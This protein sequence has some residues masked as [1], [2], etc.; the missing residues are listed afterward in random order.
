MTP[1]AFYAPL[2]PPA[3]PNPSGDREIARNLLRA[4]T[5]AQFAPDLASELR[6]F[7]KHGDAAAQ[8]G[9]IAE[10]AAQIPD[11]IARGRQ[12]GWRLW[13]TYHNYYKAPDLLGPAVAQALNIP[14]VQIEST[15][16]RKRLAGPWARF[17]EIA[18]AAADAAHVIFYFTRRDAVAL[19]D[20]APDGQNLAHLKPFLAAE[21][22]PEA[23]TRDGPVLVAAMMRPGDKLESYRLIAQSMARMAEP[24]TLAIAGDGSARAEVEALM[25]PLGDRVQFLGLLDAPNLSAAYHGARL[26]FW[27]GVNEAIGMIYLEAQAAGVPVLAQD[28]PGLRDVLAPGLSYPAPEAGPDGLAHALEA[29]LASP[30]PAGPIRAHIKDHH[31]LPAAA[32]TLQRTLEPLL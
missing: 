32:R 28:R 16:A 1:I 25:A 21:T 13:L 26:L 9:L 11:L 14:Y 10:A 6:S 31:L 2:K 7:E 24:P 19:R 17:A 20:Y 5:L 22:L 3:H 23:G 27:P 30:P 8:T 12:A 15:R 18:E 29:R 4:L